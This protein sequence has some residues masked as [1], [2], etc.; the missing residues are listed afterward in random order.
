M[1]YQSE[2]MPYIKIQGSYVYFLSFSF[3][4][5]FVGKKQRIIE[6]DIQTTIKVATRIVKGTQF[7]GNLKDAGA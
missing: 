1:I 3:K 2:K 4:I 5:A 7:G 6:V